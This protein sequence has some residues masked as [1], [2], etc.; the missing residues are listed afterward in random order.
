MPKLKRKKLLLQE[1]HIGKNEIMRRIRCDPS[2]QDK[3][4]AE[5]R[6]T[7]SLLKVGCVELTKHGD[8]GSLPR[9][10]HRRMEKVKYASYSW[11]CRIP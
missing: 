8:L 7:G 4:N 11:S 6:A 10:G 5:P 9:R 1:A 3:M 2:G